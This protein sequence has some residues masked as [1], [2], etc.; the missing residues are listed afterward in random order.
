MN[1]AL[2]IRG[3]I[4]IIVKIWVNHCELKLVIFI[5][6]SILLLNWTTYRRIRG[7]AISTSKEFYF[8][9]LETIHVVSSLE[10]IILGFF[11][12]L[13]IINPYSAYLRFVECCKVFVLA[14][15]NLHRRLDF[16]SWWSMSSGIVVNRVDYF[17]N[18]IITYFW[19]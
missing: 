12:A 13:Q 8:Q 4:I 1:L 14:S 5:E 15:L 10:S 19:I 18:G 17:V 7:S 3:I 16:N 11:Y 2:D 9:I 6:K